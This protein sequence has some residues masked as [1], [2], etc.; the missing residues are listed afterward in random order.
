MNDPSTPKRSLVKGLTYRIL[1]TII[2]MFLVYGLTGNL[3]VS[4]VIGVFEFTIKLLFYYVHERIW[5]QI[6][7]GKR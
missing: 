4:G 5:H 1:S 6:S 2:T 3:K 7:W